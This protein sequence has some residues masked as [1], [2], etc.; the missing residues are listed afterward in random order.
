MK[1]DRALEILLSL[2]ARCPMNEAE[3]MGANACID[4][5]RKELCVTRGTNSTAERITPAEKR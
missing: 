2:L 1:P 4:I 5:I 3:L